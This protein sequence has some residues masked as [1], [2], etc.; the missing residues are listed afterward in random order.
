MHFIEKEDYSTPEARAARYPWGT[1]PEKIDESL[2]QE[3]VEAD[4]AII[5]KT[6][7]EAMCGEGT[8]YEDLTIALVLNDEVY[9]IGCR[10][11]SNLCEKINELT[12]EL[13]EDGTLKTLAE[14]YGLAL[15]E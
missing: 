1:P 12:A 3:T 14:K 7:A 2:I 11:G 13:T 8:S 15:A 4:V 5:D 10:K 6:M 9:G